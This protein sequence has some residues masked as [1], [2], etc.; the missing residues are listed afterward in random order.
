MTAISVLHITDNVPAAQRVRQVLRQ[1]SWPGNS[2]AFH[3]LEATTLA[4]GLCRLGQG[5]VDVVLLDLTL[6][7]SQGLA[8][9]HAV[10]SRFPAV[11]V[12]VLLDEGE[13]PELAL[14]AV[15]EGAQDC[16]RQ[17][18]V[19]DRLLVHTLRY[20]L[21]RH[22]LWRAQ[23]A[24]EA[25]LR[26]VIYSNVDGILVIDRRG[27][28]RF[29]NPAAE[30]LFGRPRAELQDRVFGYPLVV[31]DTAEIEI[32]TPG[33][34]LRRVEMR[35]VDLEWEG[36]RAYLASLRDVTERHCAEEA[37]RRAQKLEALGRLA[38]GVAHDFN[39]LL[40]AI[41]GYSDL[42]LRHPRCDPA[43]HHYVQQIIKVAERGAGLVRQLLTFSRNQPVEPTLLDLNAVVIDLS[44]I[45]RRVL[46]EDILLDTR[47][48][49]DLGLIC[50]DR[51]QLEQVLMNLAVNARDAMPGDGTL[52]IETANV[53]L[54]AATAQRQG[55]VTG[56]YVCLTVSDTGCGMDEATQ[57]RIFEPFF[58]TKAP[59][60]GT[61]LGLATVY[62]IVKQSGGHIEVRSQVGSGST[63]TIYLPRVAPGPARPETAA[64]VAQA[65]H[66]TETVLLVE[67]N[68][69]IRAVMS[70]SLREHGY[71]VLVAGDGASALALV[72]QHQGPLDLLI[73]DV[74]M[75]QLGGRELAARLQS[76]HPG[77]R[78]LYISGYSGTKGP[79]PEA[80]SAFL[81]KPFTPEMLVR[82]VREL[83]DAP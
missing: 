16:L 17:R 26:R 56:P 31:D 75:P 55:A 11:P 30:A 64:P 2:L 18:E 53:E 22:R 19:E 76:W 36:E 81:P 52:R 4:A 13:A 32:L 61:G 23:Q 79:S 47:L 24:S 20:A 15:Q 29:L 77:L 62:G 44:R 9:L 43:L 60:K 7:D 12:V 14:K 8:T 63:F 1:A 37:L 70:A 48:A 72:E 21:E 35:V 3:L 73:T 51:N 40:T 49:P 42:V 45:L 82:K 39:N 38:G 58:T 57:A 46:G 80:G 54:D 83:L 50:A 41:F 28:I 67:D 66:G 25:Q 78:V 33:G 68:E 65:L 6:P 34:H 74:V 10:V 71:R 59:G 69:A 27:I 5:G